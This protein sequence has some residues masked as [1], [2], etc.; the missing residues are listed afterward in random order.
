MPSSPKLLH[1]CAICP[2]LIAYRRLYCYHLIFVQNKRFPFYTKGA[3][4]TSSCTT[5]LSSPSLNRQLSICIKGLFCQKANCKQRICLSAFFHTICHRDPE[6]HCNC[7]WGYCVQAQ[8][9]ASRVQPSEWILH[10]ALS[11]RPPRCGCPIPSHPL[12]HHY[13]VVPKCTKAPITGPFRHP[14]NLQLKFV[15][16]WG[17]FE[18]LPHSFSDQLH[19]C[20]SPKMNWIPPPVKCKNRRRPKGYFAMSSVCQSDSQPILQFANLI[21]CIPVY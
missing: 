17:T 16:K 13:Q 6:W 19:C 11:P 21:V 12:A 1:A 10:I 2:P 14:L 8:Y 9:G 3:P 5:P 4:Q 18:K 20:G 7:K 15:P